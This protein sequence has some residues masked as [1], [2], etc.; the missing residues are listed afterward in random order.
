[1]VRMGYLPDNVTHVPREACRDW[2]LLNPVF[3]SCRSRSFT[4]HNWQI[5]D[6]PSICCVLSCDNHYGG[7]WWEWECEWEWVLLQSYSKYIFHV[8]RFQRRNSAWSCNVQDLG[9]KWPHSKRAMDHTLLSMHV[10][11]WIRYLN[12]ILYKYFDGLAQDCSNS[13]A[14]TLGLLQPCAK[15]A[16]RYIISISIA[17]LMCVILQTFFVCNHWGSSC[18]IRDYHKQFWLWFWFHHSWHSG[19]QVLVITGQNSGQALWLE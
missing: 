8:A 5:W 4:V 9:S 10:C 6:M 3:E 14:N 15:D 11:L 16:R 12:T 19:S 2:L 13:I 18:M 17:V 7:S 1:M